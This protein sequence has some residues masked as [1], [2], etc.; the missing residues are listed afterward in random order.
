MWA[1]GSVT[2][3]LIGGAFAQKVSWTWIFW[4]NVPIIAVGTFAIVMFLRLNKT[5]GDLVRKTK[6]F[7]WLGSVF[8]VASSVSFLVPLT[9]NYVFL[10]RIPP[11]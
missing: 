1:I 7:D 4:M 10:V 9:W 3:P 6:N 8:F 11:P 2:G 5:H